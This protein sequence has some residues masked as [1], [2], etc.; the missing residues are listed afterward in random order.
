MSEF[1]K[2]DNVSKIFKVGTL[3]SRISVPAVWKVTFSLP[4]RPVIFSLVG[5]SG[6]GKSTL[7]NLI[8]R[9]IKPTFGKIYLRGKKLEEYSQKEFLRM[10]QP[11]FQ[12]PFES[13][14]P[15]KKVETYIFST[16][17]A[18]SR[19]GGRNQVIHLIFQIHHRVADF[20]HAV[21]FL[22]ESVKKRCHHLSKSMVIIM[23]LAGNL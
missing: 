3:I 4:E 21:H 23:L 20:I 17:K 22:K 7:A 9:L 6:S 19:D 1:L 14:N 8:L 16:A 5:E 13:F 12:N 15:L 10:V 2:L 11:I 18:F